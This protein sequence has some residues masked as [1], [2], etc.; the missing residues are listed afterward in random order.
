MADLS[1]LLNP[2][3]AFDPAPQETDGPDHT[4]SNGHAKSAHLPPVN[5]ASPSGQPPI[6]SPLD[7]LA[8]AAT[9]S[10]PLLSPT[11]PNSSPFNTMTAYALPNPPSS[12]RPTSSHITPPLP[13]HAPAPT[14]PT[15]SAGLQQYHHP[16]SKE[17][18]ARRPSE[19]ADPSADSLP[20]LR[21]SLPDQQFSDTG[22]SLE[23][24][25]QDFIST[26]I[27]P[28][29]AAAAGLT[30]DISPHNQID[31]TTATSQIREPSPGPSPAAQTSYLPVTTSE[32]AKVKTEITDIAPDLTSSSQPPAQ[33][34]VLS[35]QLKR[36]AGPP[37][38]PIATTDTA[39]NQ[40]DVLMSDSSPNAMLKPPP[41]SGRKRPAPKKGTATAIKPATKKR[42][43]E[44]IEK[45]VEKSSPRRDTPTSSR[46]SK[47]PA[48]RNRKRES[49]TPQRSSSV[50]NA[51]E[52]DDEDGVFCICRGPDNHTWMIACD[53][54]CE[55]WFHGRCINMTEKEGDLIEK[56]YCTIAFRSKL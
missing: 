20:P 42:K 30:E 14:S 53:G 18:R 21:Q 2:A 15:F 48:P 41:A 4:T 1:S 36:E 19:A 12:S 40:T 28:G 45:S 22:H 8:E 49:A 3:P 13:S 38:A 43:V 24:P 25:P 11:N 31:E 10:V 17:I 34:P 39:V 27:L 35:A 50:A 5:T 7:T 46:A 47:T 32:Q 33:L 6:K 16:T 55:D 26:T 44:N 37:V 54:P 56:Y 9:S 29:I 23:Q 52:E 51:D